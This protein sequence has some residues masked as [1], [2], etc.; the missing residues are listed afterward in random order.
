MS[1]DLHD[2]NTLQFSGFSDYYQ[3]ASSNTRSRILQGQDHFHNWSLRF[4]GQSLAGETA[5]LLP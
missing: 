4:Y 2:N 3:N 1:F 5:V